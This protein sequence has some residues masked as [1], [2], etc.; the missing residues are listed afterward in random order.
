MGR[1]KTFKNRWRSIVF[2]ETEKKKKNRQRLL[3]VCSVFVVS[4]GVVLAVYDE[5]EINRYKFYNR[6]KI[7]KKNKYIYL[8]DVTGRI[9]ARIGFTDIIFRFCWVSV[10]DGTTKNRKKNE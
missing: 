4:P 1:G 9:E 7:E 8:F 2:S 3:Y 5:K 10:V 6:G